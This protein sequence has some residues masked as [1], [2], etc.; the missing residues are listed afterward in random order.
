MHRLSRD[1]RASQ[2]LVYSSD[3]A[4]L[5]HALRPIVTVHTQTLSGAALLPEN[6]DLVRHRCNR[7]SVLLQEL[8]LPCLPSTHHEAVTLQPDFQAGLLN[9]LFV[10]GPPLHAS[11]LAI[12]VELHDCLAELDMLSTQ[13]PIAHGCVHAISRAE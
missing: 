9:R 11:A 3:M 10:P 12:M 8:G 5:T 7:W 4:Q 13:C 1:R 6:N 2:D